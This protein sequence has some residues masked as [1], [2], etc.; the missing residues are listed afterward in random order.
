MLRIE[1]QN[2]IL[3]SE[4]LNSIIDAFP[5]LDN[6]LDFFTTSFDSTQARRDGSVIYGIVFFL[7]FCS[8]HI[9][10]S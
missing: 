8:S 5:N 7:F 6:L 3:K 4:K 10:D 9:Q 2:G 1:R